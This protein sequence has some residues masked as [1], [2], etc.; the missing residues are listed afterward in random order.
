M[1]RDWE[2]QL[3]EWGRPPGPPEQAKMEATEAQIRAALEVSAALKGHK[4]QTA[5][6]G[7]YYNLTHVPRESDVDIRVVSHDAI[8]DDWS[9]VD[10]RANT[11]PA[12]RS[13]L[14]KRY[15]L[16]AEGAAYGYY[17]FRDDVGDALVA[18]FGPP[19]AVE[20][21]DKA[22]RIHETRYHVDADVV[23]VLEHRTYRTDGTY[24]EGVQF[25]T[26]AG[27]PVINWPEQQHRNGIEKNKRTHERFKAMVRA[28]KNLRIEMEDQGKAVAKK[29]ISSFLIEC[30][31][32]N[33]P[34][35]RFNHPTYYDD[36][37]E[38]LRFL[39][40]STKTIEGCGDWLEESNL[41]WLFKGD[42]GWTREQVN[43]FVLAAWSH[44]GF[45]N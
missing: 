30:L 26:R 21:G 31:V 23:A 20:P 41:K 34:D 10:Q 11:D 17:A 45:T 3:R 12:L 8:F 29:P 7:S 1:P 16:T 44:V 4:W 25:I 19:P 40:H 35:D 9:W 36:M 42:K 37:K 18:R 33:V 22:F 27:K 13:I 5:A 38:V 6:Q 15:G 28:L 14:R 39:Y 43:A 24:E 32:W 2:Q